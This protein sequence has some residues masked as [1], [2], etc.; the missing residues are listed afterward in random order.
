[1]DPLGT[2]VIALGALVV[3]DLTAMRLG[4]DERRRRRNRTSRRHV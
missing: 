1:M 2:L 3:L 4:V